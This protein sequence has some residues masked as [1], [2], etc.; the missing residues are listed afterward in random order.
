MI[1]LIKEE[2]GRKIMTEWLGLTPKTYS[3]KTHDGGGDEKV[4]GRKKCIILQDNITRE[5]K[6]TYNAKWP[7]LPDNS[8]HNINKVR[9]W[10]MKNKCIV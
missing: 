4:E 2:L 9:L 5:N 1:G 7:H 6:V 8:K 10:I 3:Y